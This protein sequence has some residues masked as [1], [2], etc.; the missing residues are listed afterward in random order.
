MTEPM[1][2]NHAAGPNE[3]TDPGTVSRTA[4]AARPDAGAAA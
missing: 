1:L 3:R 4:V 2:P